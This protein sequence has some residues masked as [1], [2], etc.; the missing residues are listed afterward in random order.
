MKSYKFMFIVLEELATRCFVSTAYVATSLSSSCLD[1]SAWLPAKRHIYTPNILY[2]LGLSKFY[3]WYWNPFKLEQTNSTS[4]S[5]TWK[6]SSYTRVWLA[7]VDP[8][9]L[10]FRP[11]LKTTH[12]YPSHWHNNRGTAQVWSDSAQH[13][14]LTCKRRS[15]RSQHFLALNKHPK[16]P[17]SW[18]VGCSLGWLL[19]WPA[20]KTVCTLF[21][22]DWSGGAIIVVFRDKAGTQ[23]RHWVIHSND[24][25]GCV[26]CIF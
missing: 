7:A 9:C 25:P 4:N 1:I 21:S 8:H 11:E 18:C 26:W 20:L 15:P 19:N 2:H 22:L 17:E 12:H 13:T 6:L 10:A 3:K 23:L 5:K 14:W 24:A 16:S